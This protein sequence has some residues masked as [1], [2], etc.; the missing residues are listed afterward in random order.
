MAVTQQLL[1]TEAGLVLPLPPEAVTA[2]Q[3]TEKATVLVS[4]GEKSLHIDIVPP[5]PD[6]LADV[7]D[8]VY[9]ELRDV[10]RE[11]KRRGVRIGKGATISL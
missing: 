1:R 4:V 9:N 10:F 6:D 3:V 11:L 5:L 2:A 7:A 8:E